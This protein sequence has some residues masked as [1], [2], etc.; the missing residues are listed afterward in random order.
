M[1]IVH[2]SLRSVFPFQSNSPMPAFLNRCSC[3]GFNLILLVLYCAVLG[4]MNHTVTLP[5]DPAQ[6]DLG[7]CLCPCA[8]SFQTRGG[9]CALLLLPAL[10]S[11]SARS[12][13][14]EARKVQVLTGWRSW[15]RERCCLVSCLRG[16]RQEVLGSGVLGY[17]GKKKSP[18]FTPNAWSSA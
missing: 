1:M 18:T 7:L 4:Q 10:L 14:C 6:P 17:G 5:L 16:S 12:V 2:D 8:H 3:L 11:C 13:D 9:G 15:P